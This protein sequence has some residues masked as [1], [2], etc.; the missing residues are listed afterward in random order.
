LLIW[1]GPGPDPGGKKATID[2]LQILY[3]ENE[4]LAARREG[5]VCIGFS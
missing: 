4:Q 5:Y 3:D 1:V 2:D